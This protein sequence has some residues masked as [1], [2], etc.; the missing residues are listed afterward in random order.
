M[1]DAKWDRELAK[2]DRQLESVSDEAL[3]PT[4]PNAS[5]AARAEIAEKRSRTSTLGVV[6]RLLL[7]TAGAVG[8]MF[9]PY[10]ARCGLQLAY[11]LAAI[12][13]VTGAGVWSAVWSWRHHS[14]RAHTL[15]LLLIGW[16]LVLGAMEVLPRIGYAAPS[17]DTPSTWTCG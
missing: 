8:I 11:Y 9:W 17:L 3:F 12:L 10:D 7:A 5:P 15:S 16:G 1:A 4:K 13:V 14:G 2:I 6:A